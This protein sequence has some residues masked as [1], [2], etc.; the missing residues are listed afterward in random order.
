ME[1]ETLIADEGM[2]YTDGNT[3]GS[4]IYLAKGMNKENFYQT[5]KAEYEAL[6]AAESEISEV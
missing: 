1:R 2:I 6:Q 3:Y 4:V 5:T